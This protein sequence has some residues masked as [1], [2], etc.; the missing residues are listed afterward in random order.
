[1]RRASLIAIVPVLAL[2]AAWTIP[3]SAQNE[4]PLPKG[5]AAA[6]PRQKMPQ[7]KFRRSMKPM[8]FSQPRR[9]WRFDSAEESLPEASGDLAAVRHSGT[10]LCQRQRCR[11]NAKRVGNSCEEIAQTTLRPTWTWATERA[12]TTRH[13][14]PP[15]VRK[16]RQLAPKLDVASREKN[17]EIRTVAGLAN[18]SQ[19]R[20]DWAGTEAGRGVA[21]ARPGERRWHADACRLLA[22]A[23]EHK[24]RLGIPGEGVQDCRGQGRRR[25][26]G[27][28]HVAARVHLAQFFWKTGEQD[29]AKKWMIVA[30]RQ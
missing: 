13:R 6:R 7:R 11:R 15:V 21:S 5:D 17:L 14:S 4:T 1:M 26:Q 22:P 23:E 27:G 2:L 20:E 30:L 10:I 8:A 19:L 3:V 25:Q 12:R 9:G 24:R 16:G 29:N 18:T 28:R